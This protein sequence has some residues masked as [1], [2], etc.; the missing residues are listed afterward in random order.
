MNDKLGRLGAAPCRQRR[1]EG[2]LGV[3]GQ[4]S[5]D[6]ARPFAIALK[7]DVAGFGRVVMRIDEMERA[8]ESAPFCVSDR[9][10]PAGYLGQVIGLTAAQ[11]LLQVGLRR[12]GD[13]VAC[14]VGGRDVP[15]ALI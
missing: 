5:D 12:V 8:C 10:G 9:I 14:N 6:A 7:V 3:V 1:V 15:Q 4:G 13:K 2:L 11:E